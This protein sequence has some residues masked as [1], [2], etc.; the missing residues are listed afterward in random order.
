MNRTV[1]ALAMTGMLIPSPGTITRKSMYGSI[2]K[3]K[4]DLEGACPARV[5]P[6]NKEQAAIVCFHL[7]R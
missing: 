3:R 4:E 2:G 7:T 5:V 1:S 6:S